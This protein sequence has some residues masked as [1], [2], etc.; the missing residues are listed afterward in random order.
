MYNI[1]YKRMLSCN[2]FGVPT[3]T[4][5]FKVLFTKLPQHHAGYHQFIVVCCEIIPFTLPCWSIHPTK[6][7]FLFLVSAFYFIYLFCARPVLSGSFSWQV[8]TWVSTHIAGTGYIDAVSTQHGLSPKH[9]YGKS[10]EPTSQDQ[11]WKYPEFPV[12]GM[13]LKCRYKHLSNESTISANKSMIQATI[14][15]KILH[16]MLPL[17]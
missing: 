16:C 4:L 3:F 14:V 9:E 2:H 8:W 17:K 11:A 10:S 1:I 15:P 12:N 7:L 5:H 6:I 13:A